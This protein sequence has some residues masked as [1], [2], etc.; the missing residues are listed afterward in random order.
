MEIKKAPP[1]NQSAKSNNE[2]KILPKRSFRKVMENR[3]AS[4]QPEKRRSVFDLASE[5]DE[6]SKNSEKKEVG[7]PTL[8]GEEIQEGTLLLEVGESLTVSS[9]HELSPE[10]LTLVEKMANYIM[11]ERQNGVSTTTAIIEME[12]SALDGSEIVIDHY[13]TAPHSFNLQLSGSPE[14]TD[15][16]A[17]N[18]ASLELSLQV[19]PVLQGFRVNVLPPILG[20]KSEL[21]ARGREKNGKSGS[22]DKRSFVQAKKKNLFLI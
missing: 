13:D 19:H 2:E 17:T 3:K 5:E 21:Y 1:I 4:R 20:E 6:K 7:H 10:I 12:G 15:L 9:I 18:L 22:K 8:H 11:V 16:F 14:A